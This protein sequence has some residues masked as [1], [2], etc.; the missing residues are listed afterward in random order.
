[1]VSHWNLRS[2]DIGHLS[3]PILAIY[4]LCTNVSSVQSLSCVLL[5]VTTWSAARQASVSITISQSLLK[6]MSIGVGDDVCSVIT[7]LSLQLLRPQAL[8]PPQREARA[9]QWREALA[10]RN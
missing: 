2:N 4:C 7:L 8:D 6:L 3:I 1:M 5:F 10:C 9:L